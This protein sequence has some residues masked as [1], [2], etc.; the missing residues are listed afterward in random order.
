MNLKLDD[1]FA[2]VC[3]STKGLG[4]AIAKSLLEEGAEVVLC[5]SKDVNIE[6]AKKDLSGYGFKKFHI[7]KVNLSE[8]DGIKNLFKFA[9]SKS[10]KIDI[11]VNNCGGPD[12][13]DFANVTEDQLIDSFNKNLKNV[14]MLTKLILPLME[15]NNWGR[16]VNITSTS[17]KQPIDSLLLSNIM[18]AAVTGLS[19]SISNQYASSNIMVNNVLP[20]RILTDRILEIAEKK[21]KESGINQKD[22]LNALGQDIPIKRIG[23]PEEFAPIVTF[24]CSD[25]ASYITGNSINIDGGLIK[26]L[27]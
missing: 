27:F 9:T 18:R 17:A 14:F 5:S 26:S 11:L 24:L 20:G 10:K 16:I 25:M 15:S 22:I 12:P 7:V 1:K 6:R 21:S 3:A 2:I 23:R 19:K 13:G 4:F 8:D